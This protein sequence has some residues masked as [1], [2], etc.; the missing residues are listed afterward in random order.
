MRS[1]LALLLIV[2]ALAL[3]ALWFTTQGDQALAAGPG[4]VGP[5]PVTGRGPSPGMTGAEES[6]SEE[7]RV[8]H[9]AEAITQ[10]DPMSATT[11][12]VPVLVGRLVD[13]AGQPIA[14]GKIMALTGWSWMRTPLDMEDDG[15][16]Q[17]WTQM[18]RAESDA[19]GRFQLG[20]PL[21]AGQLRFAA[22]AEGFAPRYLEGLR[23]TEEHPQDL[24]D[25][26]LDEGITLSGK[27]I[28]R[29]TNGIGGVAI[30]QAIER[31]VAGQRVSVPG[32]GVP[33]GVSAADG[34]FRVSGMAAGPWML[35]LDSP[36]HQVEEVR[37][38]SPEPGESSGHLFVLELGD[39]IAGRV[40]GLPAEQLARCRVEARVVDEE[41]KREDVTLHPRARRAELGPGGTFD[42]A[43]L[44]PGVEHRLTLWEQTDE[45][46]Y[47]RVGVVPAVDAYPGARDVVLEAEQR[48]SLTLQAVDA[49]TGQPI[50]T[51]VIFAG[52]GSA[53]RIRETILKD[54]EDK[55][56][57]EHPGGRVTY[58]DLRP[59]A[60]GGVAKVRLIAP[61]YR[62]KL[63]ENIELARG[64]EKDL[65]EVALESGPRL[66]VT[67][68]GGPDREPVAGAR[69]VA[70][71]EDAAD[72]LWWLRGNLDYDVRE[73]WALRV[74]ETD[75]AG[76]AWVSLLPSTRNQVVAGAE[77]FV[78][79]EPEEVP[80]GPAEG[81]GLELH[82]DAGGS[83]LVTVRDEAG[84]TLPGVTV[85]RQ[86]LA[87]NQNQGNGRG[88]PWGGFQ[89]EYVTGAEG[90]VVIGPLTAGAW[91]FRAQSQTGWGG[92]NQAQEVTVTDGVQATV[93]LSVPVRATI[94]G[95]VTESRVPLSGAELSL[96]VK[97][98][99][100]QRNRGW[101]DLG[102]GG[103][104]D[105]TATSNHD[106]RYK[107]ENVSCGE[108]VLRVSHPDRY[109]EETFE[110]TIIPDG[111]IYDVELP[112]AVLEG[113]VR[114][115]DGRPIPKLRVDV[116]AKDGRSAARSGGGSTLVEDDSGQ[117][118]PD[119][120]GSR[121]QLETDA[122]G[123]YRVE[124]VATGV[125]LTVSTSG[126]F[127]TRGVVTG[128]ELAPDEVRSGVDLEVEPAGRI[129]LRLP[130]GRQNASY[131]IRLS[132]EQAEGKSLN[133]NTNMWGN[134]PR[135]VDALAAGVWTLQVY[136]MRDA[137]QLL[138]ETTV[139]VVAERV[140]EV[141]L[142]L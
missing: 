88:D 120:E 12:E 67:V 62:E 75:A 65:G 101:V 99:E 11:D 111:M 125:E 20:E 82:L 44:H 141:E 51:F 91:S 29:G 15:S 23:L 28:G 27:I 105:L 85:Q 2:L 34:S 136:D 113:T 59:P 83:V 100:S 6:S 21:K 50:E 33:L 94:S 87:A 90:T 73:N 63:V 30:L 124:G 70:A 60:N 89:G 92:D 36:G 121:R 112:T 48:S 104:G 109:M 114:Y 106:G 72:S 43:G 14:G 71:G 47:Q 79:C 7:Y 81:A 142:D 52:V 39:R 10:P 118:Q 95:V 68:T 19:A 37:G 80:A 110:V 49:T 32:R 41:R 22:R 129:T 31:G 42:I 137:Q 17:S 8:A 138:W 1:A 9:E 25:L 84:Q 56:S 74:A 16:N 102:G 35:L 93:T 38:E 133:R 26:V 3:G 126:A 122:N 76:V 107:I 64:E 61:G 98:A 103:G 139:E 123:R 96:S 131:Q 54:D 77:G 57:A 58:E 119:W 40:E 78:A 24:G 69:V 45:E 5:A 130:S 135:S 128:I 66:K 55:I 116:R 18:A 127:S 140:S 115:P 46:R 13:G 134:R 132:M 86:D 4:G 108:Y 53:E 97:S 117:L